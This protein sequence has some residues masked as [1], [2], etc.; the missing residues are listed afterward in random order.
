MV[1]GCKTKRVTKKEHKEKESIEYSETVKNTE[2]EEIKSINTEKVKDSQVI[3]NKEEKTSIEIS[4]K[5]NKENPL[6]FYNVVNGDTIDLFKVTG[7]A[8]VF[9]K[10]NKSVL[11]QSKNIVS[12]KEKNTEDKTKKKSE[13][14]IEGAIEVAKEIQNKTSDVVKKDFQPGVYITGFLITAF[15]ILIISLF[16]YIRKQTWFINF[17]K[18]FKND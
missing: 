9:F 15:L 11:D 1:L 7:N 14:I 4:G 5:V 12:E 2:V 13:G 17:F 3:L 16:L 8:D 18:K 10:S 6:M